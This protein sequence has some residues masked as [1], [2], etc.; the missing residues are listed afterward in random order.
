MAQSACSCIAGRPQKASSWARGFHFTEAEVPK[1]VLAGSRVL[2]FFSRM[3]VSGVTLAAET[4]R[5]FALHAAALAACESEADVQFFGWP[6][7]TNSTPLFR[8]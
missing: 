5:S 3:R 8:L 4:L 7:M 2:A 1:Q 6:V